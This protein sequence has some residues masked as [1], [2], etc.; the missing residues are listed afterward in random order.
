M[1]TRVSEQKSEH[2]TKEQ[3]DF[4]R[5]IFEEIK[6]HAE[7]HGFTVQAVIMRKNEQQDDI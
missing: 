4:F 3:L 1:E 5:W 7:E 2:W 6:P